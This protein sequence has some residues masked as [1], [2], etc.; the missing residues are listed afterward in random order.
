MVFKSIFTQSP[1]MESV[2]LKLTFR[3]WRLGGYLV[4]NTRC[5]CSLPLSL[6]S[7]SP[8]VS[9]FSLS[10]SPATSARLS[11]WQL[12]R[13][14]QWLPHCVSSLLLFF[15]LS[16]PPMVPSL[17][18]PHLLPLQD[19]LLGGSDALAN[20]KITAAGRLA[21]VTFVRYRRPVTSSDRQYDLDLTSVV[22][23]NANLSQPVWFVYASGPLAPGSSISAPLLLPHHKREGF[24]NGGLQ[25][26]L[27]P[28]KRA[29]QC[30]PLWGSQALSYPTLPPF[31]PPG[32]PPAPGDSLPIAGKLPGSA[33]QCQVE[34]SGKVQA[35]QACEALPGGFFLMWT[36]EGRRLS[37]AFVAHRNLPAETVGVGFIYGGAG[38]PRAGS[39]DDA[40]MGDLSTEGGDNSATSAGS[41]L[42]DVDADPPLDLITNS[43]LLVA[44]PLISSNP[45]PSSVPTSGNDTLTVT[46]EGQSIDV[47]QYS[48]IGAASKQVGGAM[49]GTLS[50]LLLAPGGELEVVS[51]NASLQAGTVT[52]VFSV[53]LP[54]TTVTSNSTSST[55]SN[56]G[57]SETSPG[58]HGV[59][60]GFVKFVWVEGLMANSTLDHT[61]TRKVILAA[62][63]TG[64]GAIGIATMNLTAG[65][66]PPTITSSQTKSLQVTAAEPD[67]PVA[68]S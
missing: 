15:T 48:L 54:P 11:P 40:S 42:S 61:Q 50:G 1:Q 66:V 27:R 16:N 55:S 31:M 68:L 38:A 17:C 21:D 52:L 34:L 29:N 43:S 51:A 23:K 62:P 8:S 35:F 41:L 64:A 56:S 33:M 44:M 32:S 36:V 26:T 7:F 57:S 53:N 22:P 37:A 39:S 6:Q 14:Y 58:V 12:Q 45:D 60:E 9:F 19:S 67:E 46:G 13:A 10:A 2:G 49:G 65:L 59:K 3:L 24:F 20:I 30:S 5:P 28:R 25:L 18:L 47:V 4:G 63:E